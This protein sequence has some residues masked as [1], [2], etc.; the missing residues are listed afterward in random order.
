M[1]TAVVLILLAAS[2]FAQDEAAL[3]AAE[4]ACGPK[5]VKFDANQDSTQHPTP[6]PE[7]GKALVYVVQDNGAVFCTECPLTK[8]GL[9]GSWVGANQGD[10]YFFF[11]VSPGEHHLCINWQ[12]WLESRSR[13]FAMA[14][15]TAE[16][17]KT[18]YFRER[19]LH[20]TGS[21]GSFTLELSNSDEGKYLVAS[22]ALSVSHPKK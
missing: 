17:G 4:A 18:Y 9:D 20:F 10:S 14:N 7:A 1:K 6:Q 2:A 12:S 5:N 19:F 22:S 11:P 3:T 21:E 16:E 15:F 13:A 8:A